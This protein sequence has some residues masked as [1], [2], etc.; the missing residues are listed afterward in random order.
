MIEQPPQPEILQAYLQADAAGRAPL[1]A[2]F[3]RELK[4]IGSDQGTAVARDWAR[5]AVSPGLDYS[6]LMKLRRLLLPEESPGRS[7]GGADNG[8]RLAILGG[9]T[10]IQLRQ[11]IEV[12]LL[13]EGIAAVIYEGD[14]GL[15]RQ[16]ILTPGSELD[17]FRPQVVF[18]ATSARD[19][20][21]NP[22]PD[23][24]EAAVAQS[25][26]EEIDA[27]IHLWEI[28]HSKWNATILQNNFDIGPGSA[29]GHYSLRQPAAREC[30][31]ERLNRL[32]A[33][34]APQY[35]VLHDL[36]G[37]AAEAGA[38]N[39]FDPRFYFEFK[40]PCGPECLVGYAHSVVALIRA[41]VGRS[42][43]VL[44]LDLDNTLWGGVVGDLGAGG[45]RLGPGSGEGE[46]FLAFQIYAKQLQQRG[47]ILA[48][49]SKNDDDK[50]REP[51]EKRADMV[52]K[53]SDISCFIANWENKADNLRSI[54]ERLDLKPD[55]FV[56][57]DDNPAERALVRRLA[58]DVA[59]PD[60]P[61]DP[62]GY[63]QALAAHRYFETVAFTREDLSRSRYYL[64]N[65][66]RQEMASRAS[67]VGSFLASLAM[68][69]TIAPI[70]E[71]N[72][73]RATQLINKS[74]Q[75]NLTTRRY[76]LTQLR[77]LAES[78]DWRTL[79]F[80]LRDTLGDNGLISVLLLRK[81]A[82]TLAVDTW[83]MSCRVLQRGVE[84]FTRNQLVELARQ[85]GCNQILGTYIPTAKNGM[86]Q[87]HFAK[88]GFAAA[89]SDGAQ[90]FWS[91]GIDAAIEPLP[92][93]IAR[94]TS[95]G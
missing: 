72:I 12:F 38:R 18:L 41:I 94:E 90:S 36:R 70:D 65:A 81:Q 11:L 47:V 91:L 23:W 71:L 93:F 37:L 39:W 43:K 87:D 17:V 58:S 73:E 79:T 62:A 30:Y 56:F 25:A 33:E 61:E 16:E 27:W 40:M 13:G 31:L 1:F 20:C 63:V 15:F 53:L 3:V 83:V 48:V 45:V 75:F 7:S 6:S 64:E 57:A 60:L 51:F 77:E 66:Q 74:N 44:V 46:A 68:R 26:T 24:D 88:L 22:A 86:V 10:T 59:V 28:C 92:H 5:R 14:Y 67:D 9:S 34:C 89:G 54:A 49:C 4:R 35:V 19:V 76:T 29:W 78:S 80:S 21:R 8:L 50:A 84:Y 95:H 42:K 69:M 32:L 55:S 2:A 52:L 85:E 82:R